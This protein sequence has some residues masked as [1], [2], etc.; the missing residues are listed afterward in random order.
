MLRR[1]ALI[2]HSDH[3]KA[4]QRHTLTVRDLILGGGCDE[5]QLTFDGNEIFE[6]ENVLG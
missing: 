2:T 6:E 4:A 5:V 3:D 1:T